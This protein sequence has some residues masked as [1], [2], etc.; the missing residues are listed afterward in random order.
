MKAKNVTIEQLE[1]A[2]ELTNK[3]YDNNIIWNRSP[4]YRGK[5]LIFT[6]KVKDSKGKGARRGF[7]GKRLAHACWHVHGDFFDNLFEI[8]PK[9]VVIATGEEITKNYGNWQDRNIGS[10]A[11]PLYFS[12]ACD[13]QIR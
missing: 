5:H 8:N 2:L 10:Q 1:K 12:Q 4:E 7:S 11:C 6:L 13:C 9:A 3:Q